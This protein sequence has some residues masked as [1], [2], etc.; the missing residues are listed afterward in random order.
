M[1]EIQNENK[2][3]RNKER[4]VSLLGFSFF[5]F[6]L[7]EKQLLGLVVGAVVVVVR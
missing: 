1:K 2:K 3:E 5:F 7:L 4:F 6:L